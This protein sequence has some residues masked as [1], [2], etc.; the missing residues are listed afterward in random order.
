[1]M[2]AHFYL[3]FFTCFVFW[4]SSPVV[5]FSSSIALSSLLFQWPA[6]AHLPLHDHQT[7][8]LFSCHCCWRVCLY[9]RMLLL[10]ASQSAFFLKRQW[11][12]S[13]TKNAVLGQRNKLKEKS[14]FSIVS[15]SRY[16]HDGASRRCQL[17]RA[18]TKNQT[19]RPVVLCVTSARQPFQSILIFFFFGCCYF[20]IVFRVAGAWFL[21]GPTRLSIFLFP[22]FLFLVLLLFWWFDSND[23][24]LSMCV[25]VCVCVWHFWTG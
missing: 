19:T 21:A 11:E 12:A 7:I 2:M 10:L 8:P 9:R 24:R 5:S 16:G 23:V 15:S 17:E 22:F 1:M 20:W 13:E 3:A 25:C 6:P 18:N 14:L 4:P